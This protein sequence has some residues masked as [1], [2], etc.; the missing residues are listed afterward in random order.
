MK[1]WAAGAEIADG[2]SV[3]ETVDSRATAGAL[4]EAELGPQ[5]AMST[6]PP[7]MGPGMEAGHD[8]HGGMG[9]SRC[10]VPP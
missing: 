10:E 2:R 8:P 5:P 9:A 7:P 3:T 1:S 6:Q 4:G